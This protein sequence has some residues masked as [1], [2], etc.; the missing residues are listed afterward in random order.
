M[1]DRILLVDDEADFLSV[2]SDWLRS[3][4]YEVATA[5]DGK[6]ALDRMRESRF[7]LV[8]L[9]LMMPR[10]DGYQFCHAIHGDPSLQGVPIL[11]L[12][13]VPRQNGLQKSRLGNISGY[14]EKI[15]DRAHISLAISAALGKAASSGRGETTLDT[16]N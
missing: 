15:S 7:S 10:F 3:L 5:E 1:A 14:M 12:S 2:M 9:D 13:A 4:G 8:I 6:E 16:L 11:V